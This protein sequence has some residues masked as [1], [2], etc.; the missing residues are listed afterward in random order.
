MVL[1]LQYA[2]QS[3]LG[4]GFEVCQMEQ[5]W[6]HIFY[7]EL[8]VVPEEHPVLLLEAPLTPQDDR[9]RMVQMMFE[10]FGVPWC[11]HVYIFAGFMWYIQTAKI[12]WSSNYYQLFEVYPSSWSFNDEKIRKPM[13]KMGI[14]IFEK[15]LCHASP[16]VHTGWCPSEWFKKCIELKGMGGKQENQQPGSI[17]ALGHACSFIPLCIWPEDWNCLGLWFEPDACSACLWN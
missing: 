6:H 9:E 5:I 1:A 13:V 10:T 2:L 11:C 3:M 15:H 8:R 14:P 12:M 16:H 7:N 17:F 4:W